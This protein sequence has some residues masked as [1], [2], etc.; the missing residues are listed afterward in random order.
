[1]QTEANYFSWIE[2]Y[3]YEIPAFD[4]TYRR[5]EAAVSHTFPIPVGYG[6]A[7]LSAAGLILL[8]SHSCQILMY[9]S[10]R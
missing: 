6:L 7:A 5:V 2:I 4:P 3:F 8:Q 1:M 10:F 9:G